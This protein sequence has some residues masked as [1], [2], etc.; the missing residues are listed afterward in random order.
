MMFRADMYSRVIG[1]TIVDAVMRLAM[2]M[3]FSVRAWMILDCLREYCLNGY[4]NRRGY[5]NGR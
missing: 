5:V 3:I 1:A 2:K 4:V